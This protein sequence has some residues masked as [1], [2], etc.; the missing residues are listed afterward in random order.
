MNI[1]ATALPLLLLFQP[2]QP[3]FDAR[4]IASE[5]QVQ[6][7]DS[8]ELAIEIRVQ[9]DWHVYDPIILDTGSPTEIIFHLPPGVTVDPPRFPTPYLA[10]EHGME[11]LAHA[12]TF[13]VLTTLH[14]GAEL[15]SGPFEIKTDLYGLACKELCVPVDTAATLRLNDPDEQPADN[16]ADLV[17]KAAETLPPTLADADYLD[18]G[19]VLVEHTQV[20]IGESTQLIVW[21][22]IADDHHIQ[23]RNP[24]EGFIPTRVFIQP[25]PGIQLDEDSARWPKPHVREVEGVG[26]VRELAGQ[27]AIRVPMRIEDP[28]IDTGPIGLDVLVQYQACEDDGQCFLP[29]MAA[30]RA[31]FEIVAA[32]APA[33]VND[34]PLVEKALAAEIDDAS[35]PLDRT[36]E[37]SLPMVFLLA[38]VGG[39]ILNVMPCVLPV[40]SLKILGFVQQAGEERGRIFK[41]GLVYA[42][43]ILLSF[44]PI[45]IIMGWAGLAWGGLMQSPEFLI[46]LSAVVFAFALSLLGVFEF[47]LPGSAASAAGAAASRE[48]Y[49]GALLNGVMT[50]LLATPCVAPFLGSAIGILA[51]LEPVVA[52]SGIMVVGVGL[53]FPYVLLTAF[54]GWL[55][56][57]PKPGNWMITFKQIVGFVLVAVVL[58]LLSILATMVDRG[59]LLG[60]LG[61]LTAV[62]IGC[63]VLSKVSL[64][65]PTSRALQLWA[66]ALLV[67]VLGGWA[68]FRV[69]QA[70]S[71][72]P[73]Q[74]WEPGIAQ[75]LAD[76]GYTVYVDYTADWC[77][78]CQ[79]NKKLVL[80][81]SRIANQFRE[82]GVYP[83]KGDFTK[84]NPD[85]QAE[86]QAH[87][88]NGVPLNIVV[89]ANRPD[90]TIV[91]PEV[92]TSQTVL[93]ALE[94]AGPSGVEPAFWTDEER[95]QES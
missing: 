60:T 83:V 62:S 20:P 92:L 70:T 65:A 21:L 14:F 80:E 9:K 31:E 38:F 91:L 71:P 2:A 12:G 73:W 48:G 15:P 63:W 13:T 3:N 26:T 55:K 93:D 84:R 1:L 39:V 81:R 4:L 29:M 58:W 18:D 10:E 28:K 79:A 43:G 34:D 59:A 54:P 86:L 22:D 42:G 89:P 47:Q 45:A 72:I 61:L 36:P 69:F 85:M 57:V 53:A 46:G 11:Y 17:R 74:K 32:D 95:E 23:D 33:V 25:W 56:F 50:T 35:G 30:G 78:T 6:P 77:L 88:R 41:M 68:S 51:T 66:I 90:A 8:I 5:T 27:V 94:E 76:E 19:R 7:G 64:S 49:G 37:Y 40:I 75:R 87:G 16:A 52:A 44:L 82:L 67:T 24:P